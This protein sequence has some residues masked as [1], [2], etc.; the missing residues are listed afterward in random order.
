MIALRFGAVAG[1]E[2]QV[3]IVWL[4]IDRNVVQVDDY[5]VIVQKLVDTSL[6]AGALSIEK[7]NDV[8]MIAGS[9][10]RVLPGRPKRK[11]FKHPIIDR[12]DLLPSVHKYFEPLHLAASECRLN[13]GHAVVEAKVDLLVVPNLGIRPGTHASRIAC[14]SVASISPHSIS[15]L[16]IVCHAHAAL[17]GG[18]D[19]YRVKAED[20]DLA[21][22]AV[23]DRL[24]LVSPTNRMRG[25]LDD[26]EPVTSRQDSD[27]P[28]IA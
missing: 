12:S 27:L 21:V 3:L 22:A 11:I 9:R 4:S 6:L 26:S 2:S 13:V 10:C 8:E 23:T 15:E 17:T 16:S 7:A 24:T 1:T 18:D 20:R 5:A 28:H 14:D 19:L 25:V